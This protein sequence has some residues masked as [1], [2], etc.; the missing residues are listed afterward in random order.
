MKTATQPDKIAPLR[1]FVMATT[2]VAAQA[3]DESSRISAIKPL[4]ARLLSSDDRSC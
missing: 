2:Q 3:M 1:E 4:L